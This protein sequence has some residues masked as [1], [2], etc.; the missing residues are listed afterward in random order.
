MWSRAGDVGSSAR[1]ELF[2][3]NYCLFLNT[4]VCVV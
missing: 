2:L 3:Y 1:S 4:K